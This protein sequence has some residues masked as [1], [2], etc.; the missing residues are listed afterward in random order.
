MFCQ[1]GLLPATP[2]AGD[3]SIAETLQPESNTV[4]SC[5]A[6]MS[7][8]RF[9]LLIKNREVSH[10][11]R[12]AALGFPQIQGHGDGPDHAIGVLL[13]LRHLPLGA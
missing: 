6:G 8:P 11:A 2:E 9:C 3:G 5:L 4:L 12:I 10:L 13:H 1:D 7:L